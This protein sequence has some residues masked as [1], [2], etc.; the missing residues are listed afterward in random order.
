MMKAADWLIFFPIFW[1]AGFA[2]F[3]TFFAGLFTAKRT[4]SFE[5]LI[6]LLAGTVLPVFVLLVAKLQTNITTFST[7][8]ILQKALIFFAFAFWIFAARA[9]AIPDFLTFA[10]S[11]TQVYFLKKH[12]HTWVEKIVFFALSLVVW[13]FAR[14]LTWFDT[15][16]FHL[17]LQETLTLIVSFTFINICLFFPSWVDRLNLKLK[18]PSVFLNILLISFLGLASFRVG[19]E[20]HHG[21]FY[22]GPATLVRQGGTLLWDVPSQYGFLNILL[23][24]LV[25]TKS[26]WQSLY[27]VNSITIFIS[28][29]I[30]FVLFHGVARGTLGKLFAF[31]TAFAC[32]LIFPSVGMGYEGANAFPSTGAL[33]FVWCYVILLVVILAEKYSLNAPTQ[34]KVLIL[35]SACWVVSF[36][37]SL[38]SA[39]YGTAIW[40]PYFLLQCFWSGEKLEWGHQHLL[41]AVVRLMKLLLLLV[42]S[43]FCIG[44][45]Y[46]LRFG[47]FPDWLG[48]YEYALTYKNGFTA[49]FVDTGKAVWVLVVL[50]CGILSMLYQSIR[51]QQAG[52]LVGIASLG[53][54]WVTC[55][56]FVS[57]S[58]DNN[59]LNLMPLLLLSFVSTLK[60]SSPDHGSDRLSSLVP[61]VILAPILVMIFTV[62][63]GD[64]IDFP[65]YLKSV[66]KVPFQESIVD[67]VP[68][69]AAED[70]ALIQKAQISTNEQ[71]VWAY[72]TL[73]RKSANLGEFGGATLWLPLAPE[74]QFC[75][76]SIERQR[77]Y[78]ERFISRSDHHKQTGGWLMM[79]KH[80]PHVLHCMED[81]NLLHEFFQKIE[82][83]ESKNTLLE[84]YILKP[85]R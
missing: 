80:K 43:F 31:L 7:K 8:K 55:S 10:L 69:L 38:E 24:A 76:L 6:Y 48:F 22:V 40:I 84:R 59:I 66:L 18:L 21:S 62:S 30:A 2:V 60:A 75:I 78:L 83:H 79:P 53:C 4:E 65:P 68:P 72:D 74:F 70:S 52:L 33:R 27:I 67:L 61:R 42:L 17:H 3:T 1:I 81:K 54:F 11:L 41:S 47:F 34:K 71:L 50:Y 51:S 28:A 15:Q 82:S 14:S 5:F 49:L 9:S 63:Y 45:F 35:G 19:L 46:Q 39:L 25:P 20:F 56:Y 44:L 29:V 58:H 77:I 37:W 64:H 32:V 13:G 36:F 73:L 16:W 12:L 23:I 57:R 26:V 85:A